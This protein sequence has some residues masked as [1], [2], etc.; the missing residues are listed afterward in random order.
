MAL[1]NPPSLEKIPVLEFSEGSTHRLNLII[2]DNQLPSSTDSK[3][4][5]KPRNSCGFQR[6]FLNTSS[7]RKTPKITYLHPSKPVDSAIVRDIQQ[8]TDPRNK[9]IPD[10]LYSRIFEAAGDPE[11]Q[12]VLEL[13]T[14]DP[15]RGKELLWKSDRWRLL[16]GDLASIMAERTIQNDPLRTNP[17]TNTPVNEESTK[18]LLNL[19]QKGAKIDPRALNYFYPKMKDQ[20]DKLITRGVLRVQPG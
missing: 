8:L 16:F 18:L 3:P 10:S 17:N 4:V 6:G 14:T 11:F 1:T 2:G 12:K 13:C 20:V 19:V 5:E 15:V 9:F 7:K